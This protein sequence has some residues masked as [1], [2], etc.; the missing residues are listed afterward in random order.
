MRMMAKTLAVVLLCVLAG[1]VC[2]AADPRPEPKRVVAA[3]DADGVQRATIVGSSYR[4]DPDI[5]VV[6]VNVPVEL[7]LRKESGMAPHDFVM[8]APEAGLDINQMLSEKPVSVRF[9][10]LKTGSHP[11]YCSQRLL[12]FQ[13][14]RDKGMA[15]TLEVVE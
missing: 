8:K 7:T 2:L 4:F 5:L 9:T 3:V 13:S 11:Y 6:K 15:G 1:A 12:F 10:P 14:H